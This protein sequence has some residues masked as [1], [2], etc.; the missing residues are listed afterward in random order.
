MKARAPR[1]M[2]ARRELL[3]ASLPRVPRE[4]FALLDAAKTPLRAYELLWRLQSERGRPT[5]PPTIYRA[6]KVLVDAGLVHR[7]GAIGVY[8]PCS[9]VDEKHEPAFTVCDQCGAISELDA[10]EAHRLLEPELKA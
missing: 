6:L 1:G 7:V 4:V 2:Q 5:P 3:L 9:R 8:V 10:T